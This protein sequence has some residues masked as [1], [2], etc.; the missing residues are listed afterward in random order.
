MTQALVRTATTFDI[1]AIAA[2]Y[3]ASVLQGTASFELHPPDEAEMRRRFEAITGAGYPYLV[4][5]LDDRIVGYAYASAYRVFHLARDVSKAR[6]LGSYQLSE[7]IGEGGMG[8]VWR[9]KHRMLARPAAV[10]LI[11]PESLG[12]DG[13]NQLR[14][15]VLGWDFKRGLRWRHPSRRRALPDRRLRFC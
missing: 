2:I 9:A 3:G 14:L 12:K 11:R 6:R 13:A 1:P 7:K 10:K 4:A 5:E 15:M 8:E